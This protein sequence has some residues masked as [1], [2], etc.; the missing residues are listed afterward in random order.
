MA[1][2]WQTIDSA[3]TP[4]G[5]LELRQRGER[6]FLLTVDNRVLMSSTAQLSE[7]A[8]GELGC[9]PIS[10]RPAPRV[11]IGGLGMGITL[12]AALDVLPPDAEV[13]VADLNPVVVAWCRGPLAALTDDAVADPRTKVEIRDVARLITKA[14][15]GPDSA[16]FD[17]ILLDLYEG[18]RDAT[19]GAADP[20]YGRGALLRS[21]KALRP[22]G[23]FAVWSEFPDGSF[24]RRLEAS[25]FQVARRRPGR[26]SRHVVYLGR[27]T[28]APPRR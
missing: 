17:A 18:P 27:P 23:M 12:R 28:S 1:R 8:L 9:R 19:Q 20:L 10:E 13:V 24:A 25:G 16:R 6:D 2:P 14:S 26:R 21:R 3:E 7:V 11:L 22:Q 5:R 4:E 15:A